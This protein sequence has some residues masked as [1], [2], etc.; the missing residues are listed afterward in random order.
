MSSATDLSNAAVVGRLLRLAWRYWPWCLGM[1]V[2][3]A[4][5]MAFPDRFTPMQQV[6]T[7]AVALIAIAILRAAFN[8]SYAIV[9]GTLVRARSSWTCEWPSRLT[10]SR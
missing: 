10:G 3:Q 6:V 2:L 9:S 1:L 5:L 8:Y 4:V 7:L